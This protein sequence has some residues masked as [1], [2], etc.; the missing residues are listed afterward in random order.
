MRSCKR[1]LCGLYRVQR[2]QDDE[3]G[4]REAGKLFRFHALWEVF[5]VEK[6]HFS[7]SEAHEQADGL[8]HQ[9][10]DMLA[11]RLDEFLGHPEHCPHGD[12]IPKADGSRK[13]LTFRTLSDLRRGIVPLSAVLWKITA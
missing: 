13:G 1:G 9:T 5:L 8:E 6:L 2:Q 11:E 7:W 12:P 4:R 3:E 10:S